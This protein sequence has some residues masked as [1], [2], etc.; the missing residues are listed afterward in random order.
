MYGSMHSCAAAIVKTGYIYYGSPHG[1]LLLGVLKTTPKKMIYI[2]S[3]KDLLSMVHHGATAASLQVI[4]YMP[5]CA[6]FPI[7]RPDLTSWLS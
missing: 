3:K 6:T 1:N 7:S 2:Y 4:K 5:G